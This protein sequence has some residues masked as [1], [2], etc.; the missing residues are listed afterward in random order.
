MPSSRPDV[1]GASWGAWTGQ[2]PIR[3]V[4]LYS[5]LCRVEYK[6]FPQLSEAERGSHCIRIARTGQEACVVEQGRSRA[7]PDCA[8]LAPGASKGPG[9]RMSGRKN[10]NLVSTDLRELVRR[11]ENLYGRGD[12]TTDSLW[13][14][15]QRV[16]RLA[17]RLGRA[18]GVDPFACRLAGLFHDAG[19]FSR[20]GYHQDDRPEEEHS[21]AC[22]REL[23]GKHGLD[24]ELINRVA[25]AIRQLYRDDAEPSPLARVL[26]D[27]DNLDKLGPLGV[28]NYFAKIGLRGRGVSPATLCRLT[29]EL[30]YARHAPR[31]MATR[32]GRDLARLRAPA[33]IRFIDELIDTLREDGLYDLRVEDVDFNGVVLAVVSPAAC[34]CGGDLKRRI[35]EVSGIKC[36]EIHLRHECATCGKGRELKLCRPRL[37]R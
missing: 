19:K 28:A 23:G 36:S 1:V 20:G 15:L 4:I 26:F 27:A 22:L 29:V 33:T 13:D 34:E 16:S 8:I 32:S 35:W 24:P 21:V 7:L 11:E 25:E 5:P 2:L 12:T 30:T 31:C 6:V 3:Q 9:I 10:L 18:E 14:H 17:E 37:N